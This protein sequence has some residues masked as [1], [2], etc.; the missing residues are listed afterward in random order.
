[1]AIVPFD[2]HDVRPTIDRARFVPGGEEARGLLA[3][4][5]GPRGDTALFAAI[6]RA[7]DQLETRQRREPDREYQLIVITDG[8]D[9]PKNTDPELRQRPVSLEAVALKAEDAKRHGISVYPIGI[10]T[11]DDTS[12]L[13][14]LERIS[15]DN[16]AMVDEPG[17]LMDILEKAQPAPA[18]QMRIAFLSPFPTRGE[19]EGRSHIVRVRIGQPG[20][21]VDAVT[22]WAPKESMT[23]PQAREECSRDEKQALSKFG[24]LPQEDY[25]D[26]GRPLATLAV[27]TC[28]LL[29]CWFL[30]PRLIWPEDYAEDMPKVDGGARWSAGRQAPA[31]KAAANAAR[32]ETDATYVLPGQERDPRSRFK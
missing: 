22:S 1:V 30:M 13:A 24:G 17:A 3:A 8:E 2:N 20:R 29:L 5:P 26:V 11:A 12:M 16:S 4:I 19:L 28:I 27:F 7:I 31:S 15:I 18:A 32:E 6:D 21:Q 9:D 25:T 14:P 23:A 10:G